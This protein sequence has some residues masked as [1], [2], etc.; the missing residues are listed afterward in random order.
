[1]S[2]SNLYPPIVNTFMPS[3]LISDGCKIYFSLSSFNSLDEIS[4]AQVTVV[5]QNTNKNAL[6]KDFKNSII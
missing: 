3:F 5:Y 6:K 4:H 2:S 1:M